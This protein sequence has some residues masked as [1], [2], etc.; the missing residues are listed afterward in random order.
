MKLINRF[1]WHKTRCP[2][3]HPYHREVDPKRMVNCEPNCEC[4]LKD[5]HQ[6]CLDCGQL[7]AIGDWSS[8]GILVGTIPMKVI[9]RL[10][11]E[12]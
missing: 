1:P 12:G 10:M 6:H 5:R 2:G 11:N 9:N 8:E 4:G 3:M 7:T